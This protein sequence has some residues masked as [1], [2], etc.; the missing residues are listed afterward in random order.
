MVSLRDSADLLASGLKTEINMAG[1]D[2]WE[3]VWL[4]D[5]QI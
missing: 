2:L 5:E 3:R 1:S 4:A